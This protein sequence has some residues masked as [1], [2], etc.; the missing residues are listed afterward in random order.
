MKTP[1]GGVLALLLLLGLLDVS[2]AQDSCTG[3]PGIPG[4]PGIPG[5]PGSNGKPGTPGTKGE[6][7]TAGFGGTLVSLSKAPSPA[8]RSQLLTRETAKAL[9]HPSVAKPILHNDFANRGFRFP[10]YSLEN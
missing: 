6:K 10:F 2:R 7:G 3:H 9:A 5:A 4:I 1:W 8:S